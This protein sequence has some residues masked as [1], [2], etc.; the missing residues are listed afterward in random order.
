MFYCLI[1]D[2]N[3]ALFDCRQC[4]RPLLAVIIRVTSLSMM[5]GSP[6]DPAL[7][8]AAVH[9]RIIGADIRMLRAMTLTGSSAAVECLTTTSDLKLTT[10][11]IYLSVSDSTLCTLITTCR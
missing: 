2:Y 6:T 7:L 10:L 11:P 8:Q 5:S 1:T 4:L 3:A 9:L